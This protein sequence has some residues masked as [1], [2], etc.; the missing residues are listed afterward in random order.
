MNIFPMGPDEWYKTR[1]DRTKK[2]EGVQG[3]EDYKLGIYVNDRIHQSY[4]MQVMALLTLNMAARWCRNI[5]IQIPQQVE[6]IISPQVG[7]KFVEYVAKELAQIDPYGSFKFENID[8]SDVDSI[9]LIG[10]SKEI[11]NTE[12]CVWIDGAGWIAGIGNNLS[13]GC[14]TEAKKNNPVGPAFSA[15]LG[16][17]ELFRRAIGLRSMLPRENWFSLF[18]FTKSSNRTE[19]ANPNNYKGI[20]VGRVVQ[21]GCGAVGSSLDYLLSLTR[22]DGELILIDY[23]QVEV[24]NCNR[25]LSFLANDAFHN[26]QKVDVCLQLF[27]SEQIDVIGVTDSFKGYI[28]KGGYLDAP[29]DIILCLAN[30][31]N[32]WSDIQNNFPPVVLHATTTPNWGI[33]FGRHI[34]KKEWCIM[35]RFSKEMENLFIPI[36]GEVEIYKTPKDRPIQGVLPF[37]SPTAAVLIL[38]EL[39]KMTNHSPLNKNFI[40]FSMKQ[41]DPFFLTLQRQPDKFCICNNQLIDDYPREIIDSKFWGKS[42]NR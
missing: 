20:D 14:G 40:Q 8:T 32:V 12:K 25:S 13:P 5:T 33:N 36:C 41:I 15:C 34:P 29:P 19:L 1:D 21:I 11:A 23:D 2:I 30:E 16:V 42:D 38:A 4:S 6:S 35:C 24:H 7:Q 39:G 22:L 9:L 28:S 37:L 3:F 10:N 27:K 26:K 17:A 31:Q 18:D